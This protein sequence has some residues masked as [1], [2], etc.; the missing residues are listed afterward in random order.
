MNIGVIAIVALLCLMGCGMSVEQHEAKVEEERK[1]FHCLSSW[2]GNHGGMEDLVRRL[3]NDPNSME[4][5]ETKITPVQPGTGQHT[6]IMTFG[7][8]NSFGGMVR[9]TAIGWID[10]D[11]CEAT[12]VSVD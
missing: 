6:I 10:H 7:G 1:G 4:T 5:Y 9:H 11:S 8:G 3:L 2:D 12:L